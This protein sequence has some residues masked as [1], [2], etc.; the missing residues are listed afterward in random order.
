MLNSFPVEVNFR[1]KVLFFHLLSCF[2]K[3][4]KGLWQHLRE[5]CCCPE[6]FH[7]T[8]KQRLY[9]SLG[10]VPSLLYKGNN[11]SEYY[12]SDHK[13]ITENC[14]T[15]L[16]DLRRIK[17]NHFPIVPFKSLSVQNLLRNVYIFG[18]CIVTDPPDTLQLIQSVASI[19]HT[20]YGGFYDFTSDMAHKDLAYSSE[21]LPLHT[22]T[23][24][25]TDPAGIQV[26]HVKM[27]SKS[28]GASIFS[29]GYFAAKELRKRYKLFFDLLLNSKVTFYCRDEKL[30][31]RT[32]QPVLKTEDFQIRFNES[33]REAISDYR[34]YA[35]LE[36]LQEILKEL[37]FSLLLKENEVLFLDNWRMLH[38]RT[39]FEGKRRVCGAYISRDEYIARLLYYQ[40]YM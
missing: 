5:L 13:V 8:T 6:C 34:V 33:D 40:Q 2:V 25:F 26:F 36:K 30:Y 3:H 27:P 28:G 14:P 11:N 29:D 16:I 1:I 23:P 7:P 39:A 17:Q 19:K 15:K 18:G 10:K 20:H 32:Q 12:F 31:Y 24:Y 21:A 38:G 4:M 37:S 35:A 22:D 9:S